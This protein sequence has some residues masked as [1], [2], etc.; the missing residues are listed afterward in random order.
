MADK[1]VFVHRA[2]VGDTVA[3]V[4]KPI[5]AG[6]NTFSVQKEG[7]ASLMTI[8]GSNDKAN[9]VTLDTAQGDAIRT[10]TDRVRWVRAQLT[11]DTIAGR[12]FK[13][14]FSFFKE[15]E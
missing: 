11:A 10:I 3:V 2:L 12:E 8:G 15:T 6:G 1:A 13:F 5:Y 4:S 7:P 9:W 14:G